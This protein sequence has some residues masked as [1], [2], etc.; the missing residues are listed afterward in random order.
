[1]SNAPF[2]NEDPVSLRAARKLITRP[3]SEPAGVAAAVPPVAPE[4]DAASPGR[5]GLES[6]DWL[7]TTTLAMSGVVLLGG[8]WLLRRR[9]WLAKRTQ[10]PVD[11]VPQP[12]PEAMRDPVP[13]QEPEPAQDPL[14]PDAPMATQEDLVEALP[15]AAAQEQDPVEDSQLLLPAPDRRRQRAASM[16]SV[17]GQKRLIKSLMWLRTVMAAA[18][19]LAAIAIVVFWSIETIDRRAG[20]TGLNM[21]LLVA[22][23]MAWTAS[24]G[25]GQ[26]ANMLHRAFFN[27]VHPKFDN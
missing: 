20:E 8:G 24:W 26:V 16:L 2:Q 13:E 4:A 23:L 9:R 6:G 12:L 15:L 5:P 18:A 3:T 21:P 19:I 17:A 25:A 11:V 27:R 10:A 14:P 22:V 1:M 7:S